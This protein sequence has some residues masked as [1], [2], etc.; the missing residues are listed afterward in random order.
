M[1]QEE[2]KALILELVEH[3]TQPKFC[4]VHKWQKGD[5]VMW[6]NRCTLHRRHG[7]CCPELAVVGGKAM[8]RDCILCPTDD[9]LLSFRID[10]G[11]RKLL[12][13]HLYRETEPF[14]DAG[15]SLLPGPGGSVYVVST[16]E[17][18]Q[19]TLAPKSAQVSHA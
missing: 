1:D 7:S 14:V 13:G 17:I 5:I 10:A 15:A 4:Y 2:S 11:T 6:D 16:R 12:K 9:G 19:L 3:A 18:G 8:V